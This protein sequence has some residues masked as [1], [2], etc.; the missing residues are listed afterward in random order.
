MAEL[1]PLLIAYIAITLV[2]A[3]IGFVTTL[4]DKGNVY[5]GVM[6]GFWFAAFTSFVF[7]AGVSIA[8]LTNLLWNWI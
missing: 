5:E 4:I 2:M 1:S 3:V 6:V 7:W 8:A